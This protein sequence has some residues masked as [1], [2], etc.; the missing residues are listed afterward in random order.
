M[1]KNRRVAMGAVE[2][3]SVSYEV[4]HNHQGSCQGE[5]TVI[6]HQQQF[7]TSVHARCFLQLSRALTTK[8]TPAQCTKPCCPEAD[9]SLDMSH[10][11]SHHPEDRS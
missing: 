9:E 11:M 1:V 8:L 3:D 5:D 4:L 6:S 2:L 7:N 10:H